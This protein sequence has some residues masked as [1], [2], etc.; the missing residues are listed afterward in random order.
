MN[1]TRSQ[2]EY[3]YYQV[4][5][6][7]AQLHENFIVSSTPSLSK[8]P[9]ADLLLS[10]PFKNFM[11]ITLKAVMNAQNTAVS[12]ANG[13]IGRMP[14][15][16]EEKSNQT[17]GFWALEKSTQK[18][19][20]L[21][22]PDGI[23]IPTKPTEKLQT[24]LLQKNG[25]MVSNLFQKW[26]IQKD[27]MI[28]CGM[29]HNIGNG[30]VLS[31]DLH[32]IDNFAPHFLPPS[33]S[34]SVKLVSQND[35][36]KLDLLQSSNALTAEDTAD[37][38]ENKIFI[39]QTSAHLKQVIENMLDVCEFIFLDTAVVTVKSCEF[40]AHLG[41]ISKMLQNYVDSNP[42][43]N[44]SLLQQ[45]H[46][47][48]Q[49]YFCHCLDDIQ[50]ADELKVDILDFSDIANDIE[51]Q[52]YIPSNPIWY[53][54][55]ELKAA[56]AQKNTKS[57]GLSNLKRPGDTPPEDK[58]QKREVENSEIDFLCKLLKNKYIRNVFNPNKI[59]GLNHPKLH[60][61]EI[62][63]CFHCVGKCDS[64]CPRKTTHVKLTGTALT[65]LC[66]YVHTAKS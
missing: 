48:I 31:S 3:L 28:C 29:A 47:C 23:S 61:T 2:Q 24:I 15:A 6:Q 25:A 50:T 49:K 58:T 20:L 64:A 33:S 42:Y 59:E 10:S 7:C 35:M 60:N 65:S 13:C 41:T 39:P 14:L 57:N 19:L 21:I 4:F 37:I 32:T 26:L 34:K 11:K 12:T 56:A 5:F 43:F 36:F 16:E 53:K 51:M 44:V 17:K 1:Y 40:L 18:Q 63:L 27:A 66:D 54:Q 62:C 55:L 22:S 52:K 45:Y 38:L 9:S 46:F 30:N 8:S